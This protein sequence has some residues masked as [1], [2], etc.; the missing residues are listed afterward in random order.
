MADRLPD[1]DDVLQIEDREL[2]VELINDE[3]QRWRSQGFPHPDQIEFTQRIDF[4]AQF[5]AITQLML[6]KGIMTPEEIDIAMLQQRVRILYMFYDDNV[7]QIRSAR[8]GIGNGQA[9]GKLYGPDGKPID[10]GR[11]HNG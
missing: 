4:R 2:L 8:L 10:I 6:D 5:F 9:P 11:K 1:L 3:Y 7:D